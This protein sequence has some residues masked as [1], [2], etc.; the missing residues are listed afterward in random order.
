MSLNNEL[1]ELEKRFWEGD[2]DFYRQNLTDDSLMVFAEPVG[3]L[4]K[5]VTVESI[6]GAVRW[7]DIRFSD[8]RV[9]SP[10]ADVSILVYKAVARREAEET[11]YSTMASSVYVRQGGKW[12]MVLHQQSPTR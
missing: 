4:E 9:L 3:I 1:L 6:A 8:V 7:R 12:Q 10:T 11:D 5:D 2:A